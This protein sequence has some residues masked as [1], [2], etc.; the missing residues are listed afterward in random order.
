MQQIWFVLFAGGGTPGEGC[1]LGLSRF[2]L[3]G[4]QELTLHSRFSPVDKL[5]VQINGHFTRKKKDK[6]AQNMAMENSR[7]LEK[8]SFCEVAIFHV[9]D[10]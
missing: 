7:R 1:E 6:V 10:I 2:D 5:L 3:S 8:R 4:I 9:R